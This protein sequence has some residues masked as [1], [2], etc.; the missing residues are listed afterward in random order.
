M[1]IGVLRRIR[2][3]VFR[4]IDRIPILQALADS[5]YQ[6]A[7]AAH[8]SRLP[9]ISYGDQTIIETIRREGI[10]VTSLGAL[11]NSIS[12]FPLKATQ[13]LIRSVPATATPNYRSYTVKVPTQDLLRYPE[14]FYW[15]L[16]AKFLNL[17]ECYLQLPVAYHG[18]YVRK[19]LANQIQV[20]S[21]LWHL[22]K[23]DRQM[24]KM[25][26][27]LNDVDQ[28]GGPFEY[29]PRAF[30]LSTAQILRYNYH[31]IKDRAMARIVAPSL[32]KSCPG[33]TG[34][35]IL[36]DPAAIFHRGKLPLKDRFTIFFDYTSRI[37][38]HPYYCKSSFSI[39]ELAL[40]VNS[41]PKWQQ[42]CVLWNQDLWARY[43]RQLKRK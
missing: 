26:I 13:T 2:N 36:F 20:G 9:M 32:W 11:A 25:I 31:L 3:K 5:K 39:E 38:K 4:E 14:L 28:S 21:R 1:I 10:F 43:H 30:T 17:I 41:L 16:E 27:Y 6:A 34:T 7:I 22:D 42:H 29:I 33:E 23:E 8:A 15:G 12:H 35:V 37:P 40:L 18:I 19:D 24:I